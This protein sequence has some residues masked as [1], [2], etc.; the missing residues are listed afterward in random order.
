M[1]TALC[2]IVLSVVQ[3]VRFLVVESV[4][5]S[6]SSQRSTDACIF[7]NLFQDLTDATLSVVSDVPIDSE[8]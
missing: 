1:T 8:T 6:S 4:H 2:W 7:L 3:L 5:Q